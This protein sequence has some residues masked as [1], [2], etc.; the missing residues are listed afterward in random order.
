MEGVASPHAQR[1]AWRLNAEQRR[2][3]LQISKEERHP[4]LIRD[5][6]DPRDRLDERVEFQA[7]LQELRTLP[8]TCGSSS[9]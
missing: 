9:W 1:E 8:K 4:G 6:P 2:A 5:P 3:S 7:A